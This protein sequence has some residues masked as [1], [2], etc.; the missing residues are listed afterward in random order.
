M[1]AALIESLMDA[2]RDDDDEEFYKK[3]LEAFKENA[4]SDLMPFNKIPIISDVA[5]FIMSRFDIGFFS[6]DNLATTWLSQLANAYDTWAEILS[7]EDTSKTVYNAIYN[8]ARAISS[9]TGVAGAGLMREAVALWNNTAGAY[10]STLKVKTYEN[11][12]A[13]NGK[14]ALE[15]LVEGDEK[16]AERLKAQFEDEE[17]Y[18]RALRNAV[19]EEYTS[20][21]ADRSATEKILSEHL[22]M[23]ADDIH[24]QLDEWDHADEE[25]YSK[26]NDLYAS[27]ETGKDLKK[28]IKV[29][30]D[31]GVSEETLASQITKHFKPL[32]REMSNSERAKL[33]GY[34]LNAYAL[35]GKKRE[36]KSKDIN[37][38]LKND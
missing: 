3:F 24:W 31:N 14:L 15:A 26:Y 17:S 22:G 28:T 2:Y 9:M 12:K 7:G 33:K 6:S 1:T 5:E 19:K 34:L 20:G 25:D 16:Q 21:T 10:D 36:D 23:E 13:E 30:L 11:T 18:Q 29:Y 37:D 32:Y 38:W 8:T 35:L 27:V 4:I